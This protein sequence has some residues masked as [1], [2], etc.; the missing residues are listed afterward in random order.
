M[1]EVSPWSRLGFGVTKKPQD[2][3]EI[4]LLRDQVIEL[5]KQVASMALRLERIESGSRRDDDRVID[6]VFAVADYKDFFGEEVDEEEASDVKS[7]E[8]SEIIRVKSGF[9]APP[10]KEVEKSEDEEVEPIG[11]SD[12]IDSEE[13]PIEKEFDGEVLDDEALSKFVE[14]EEK[15]ITEGVVEMVEQYIASNHAILNN[16]L[17]KK[18]YSDIPIND[19]IK[20]GIKEALANHPR[21]KA[22]KLDKFRTLY[23]MGEDADEEYAKAF[24]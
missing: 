21:I 17:K 14:R 11:S 10:P 22:H 16:Q 9:T 20:K 12:D 3:E 23:H 13:D 19:K 4:L 8:D 6:N 15:E 7:E 2:S 24:S 1:E 5:S 18:I